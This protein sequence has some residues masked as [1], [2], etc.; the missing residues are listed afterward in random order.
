VGVQENKNIIVPSFG[1]TSVL[2]TRHLNTLR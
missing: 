2:F 1:T